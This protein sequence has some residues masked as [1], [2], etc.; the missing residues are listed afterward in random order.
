M[1]PYVSDNQIGRYFRR[2]QL[3]LRFLAHGARTQTTCQWT[4]LTPD[5]LATLR[6]RWMFNT[7][8]RLRGP[9]P[10]SFD[11]FFASRHRCAQAALFLVI[12]RIVEL[13][14]GRRGHD[15][16][17]ALPSLENGERLCEAFE[18][19][20]AWE[21]RADFEFEQAKLLLMG[22][23]ASESIELSQCPQC[24]SAIVIDKF[25]EKRSSCPYC[26]K[27]NS[28]ASRRKAAV[29]AATGV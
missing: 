23:V 12:C 27:K 16:A 7:D 15:V 25:A 22:A 2:I 1:D 20:R 18:L 17:D 10:S 5:Q 4:G 29:A 21:T 28:H 14:P 24:S 9:S 8:D 26:R 3:G 19:Y 11:A 13:I 6:R